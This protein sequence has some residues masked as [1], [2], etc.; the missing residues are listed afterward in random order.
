VTSVPGQGTH[1]TTHRRAVAGVV[2]VAASAISLVG[3]CSP[4]RSGVTPVSHIQ[5]IAISAGFERVTAEVLPRLEWYTLGGDAKSVFIAG[6]R[7]TGAH[8]VNPAFVYDVAGHE[9]VRVDPAP[10]SPAADGVQSL[11]VGHQVIVTGI[12]CRDVGDRHDDPPIRQCEPGTTVAAS[13]D[14]V[15]RRWARLPSPHRLIANSVNPYLRAVGAFGRTAVF[16]TPDRIVTFDD[17]TRHWSSKSLPTAPR[18]P[19]VCALGDG[20]LVAY[21]SVPQT[22]V[23]LGGY[24]PSSGGVLASLA[25]H[26]TTWV[27]IELPPVQFFN[28]LAARR[29]NDFR[30]V[31]GAHGFV[32]TDGQLDRVWYRDGATGELRDI[33]P[34]GPPTVIGDPPYDTVLTIA[35]RFFFSGP[36]AIVYDAATGAWSSYAPGAGRT[37]GQ[38]DVGRDVVVGDALYT[39]WADRPVPLALAAFRPRLTR[40]AAAG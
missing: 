18:S 32:L 8:G 7:I 1:H 31:C 38:D 27:P 29:A 2:L 30:I 12:A 24:V 35:D 26:A 9:L 34:P 23:Q 10:F 15:T 40:L 37:F 22:D 21:S 36:R 4:E 33:R 16:R 19:L 28:E 3:A 20:T 17:T 11:T 13:F 6:S 39:L 14:L 5:P 25:P